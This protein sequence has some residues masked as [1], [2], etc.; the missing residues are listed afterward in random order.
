[1]SRGLPMRECDWHTTEGTLLGAFKKYCKEC[2]DM[3]P[4]GCC[5][6]KEAVRVKEDGLWDFFSL[7]IMQCFAHFVLSKHLEDGKGVLD[8]R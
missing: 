1:M 7:S 3:C 6:L 5:R 2:N 8:E 4:M